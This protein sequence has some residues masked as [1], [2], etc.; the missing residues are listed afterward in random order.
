[1]DEKT[2]RYLQR[3]EK[4]M[5]TPKKHNNQF[6]PSKSPVNCKPHNLDKYLKYELA[7]TIVQNAVDKNNQLLVNQC[8]S[9]IRTSDCRRRERIYKFIPV[10]KAQT[11]RDMQVD[12]AISGKILVS[13]LKGMLRRRYVEFVNALQDTAKAAPVKF[14]GFTKAER[15]TSGRE[16]SGYSMLL[17]TTTRPEEADYKLVSEWIDGTSNASGTP[18]HV[19]ESS[20]K[21][22]K[23]MKELGFKIL[24]KSIAGKIKNNGRWAMHQMRITDAPYAKIN[25]AIVE[26]NIKK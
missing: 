23:K 13:A 20:K 4:I 17:R 14:K 15:K 26:A 5:L 11:L 25:K 8:F 24:F 21:D 2:Q 12:A 1:M 10:E 6:R 3:I 16:T 19:T 18:R 9:A 22:D 7:T